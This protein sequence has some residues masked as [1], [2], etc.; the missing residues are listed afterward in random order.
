MY[1]IDNTGIACAVIVFGIIVGVAILLISSHISDVKDEAYYK[2]LDKAGEFYKAG[3]G[4]GL[5]AAK[6]K[7]RPK[8]N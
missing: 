5:R 3:Y 8:T 6:N 1:C 4:I 7:R 2:G